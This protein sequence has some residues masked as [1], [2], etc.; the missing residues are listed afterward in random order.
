MHVPERVFF[1]ALVPGPQNTSS[2]RGS[3]VMPI[4]CVL[5]MHKREREEEKEDTRD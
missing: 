5:D 3:L 4:A 2:F 1:I